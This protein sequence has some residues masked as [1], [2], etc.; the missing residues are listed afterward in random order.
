MIFKRQ[1]S[2]SNRVLE[3][4]LLVFA[5]GSFKDAYAAPPTVNPGPWSITVTR[6][7]ST[8]FAPATFIDLYGVFSDVDGNCNAS[9]TYT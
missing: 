3:I 8:A 6:G 7:D 9:C 1:N 4:L 2:A 5:L